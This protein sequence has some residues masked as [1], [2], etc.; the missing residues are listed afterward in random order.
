MILWFREFRCIAKSAKAVPP[1]GAKVGTDI[2]PRRLFDPYGEQLS[3]NLAQE[4]E[5]KKSNS[6]Y[7][8]MISCQMEVIGFIFPQISSLHKSIVYWD[9]YMFQ[10]VKMAIV[11]LRKLS[12]NKITSLPDGVFSTQTNL[13]SL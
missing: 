4:T 8:F 6:K 12:S 3:E 10:T 2:C 9:I 7:F 1:F 5:K 11:F 13:Q